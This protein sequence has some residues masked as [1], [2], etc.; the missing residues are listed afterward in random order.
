VNT[1]DQPDPAA[2]GSALP[3]ELCQN[4]PAKRATKLLPCRGKAGMSRSCRRRIHHASGLSLTCIAGADI[5]PLG[6]NRSRSCQ[7]MQQTCS[8]MLATPC[9][10][11]TQGH[12]KTL[13][14]CNCKTAGLELPRCSSTACC[15]VAPGATRL[16]PQ[17]QCHAHQPPSASSHHAASR[18]A[19]TED[20]ANWM[21][22]DKSV[23]RVFGGPEGPEGE[24]TPCHANAEVC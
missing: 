14:S 3:E 17:Q 13:C 19:I 9:R 6:T 20:T 21:S 16:R 2:P 12:C 24:S 15:C 11:I 23:S 5:T 7:P 10:P 8:G 18:A 22:T 1:A 4:E